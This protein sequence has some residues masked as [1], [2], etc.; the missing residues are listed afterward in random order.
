MITLV[1]GNVA[2][3]YVKAINIGGVARGNRG[4]GIAGVIAHDACG[5]GRGVC[6]AHFG[7]A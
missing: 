1:V 3:D 6:R 5:F 2:G 7:T 4:H